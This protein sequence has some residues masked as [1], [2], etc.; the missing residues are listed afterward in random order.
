MKAAST[1]DEINAVMTRLQSLWRDGGS[2]RQRARREEEARTLKR[3]LAAL[4]NVRRGER[5]GMETEF[6][7]VAEILQRPHM[8]DYVERQKGFRRSG[9]KSQ[10][11]CEDKV[12]KFKYGHGSVIQFALPLGA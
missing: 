1:L 8:I 4:W 9:W 6:F 2:R 3:Q 7:S 5:V 12:K 10:T 11:A